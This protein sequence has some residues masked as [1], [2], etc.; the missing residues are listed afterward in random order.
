MQFMKEYL[1]F[2]S[3]TDSLVRFR[4]PFIM[5]NWS[6]VED[7]EH[8]YVVAKNTTTL[9]EIAHEEYEDPLMMYVLAARNHLDLPDVQLFKGKK[10][11]IPNRDWVESK[12][13]TQGRALRNAG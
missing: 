4:G 11:K 5:P 3:E 1:I 7:N 12:L 6:G 8:D 9:Y 10:L 2:D 13:L